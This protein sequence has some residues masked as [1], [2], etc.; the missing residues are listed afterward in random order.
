MGGRGSGRLWHWDTRPETTDF[1]LLDVRHLSQRGLLQPRSGFSWKW[2]QDGE[3]VGKVWVGVGHGHITLNYR[4][5][6]GGSDWQSYD[7]PVALLSQPCNYGGHRHWFACPARGC[8]RRIAIL[9]GGPIFACR[10]CHQ[11]AYPS[12]REKSFQRYQRRA[13]KIRE[14][15]GWMTGPCD[16]WG[17]RPKGDARKD[18]QTVNK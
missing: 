17:D 2:L 13:C 9:Y 14:G 6:A 4:H 11:L 10:S 3:E 16:P 15:F 12:Q 8:G 5:K 18:L 7:Y 1:L